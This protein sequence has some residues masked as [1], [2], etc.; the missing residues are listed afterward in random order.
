MAK[1]QILTDGFPRA[2]IDI[3]SIR[4]IRKSLI[5]KQN[6]LTALMKEVEASLI[7]LHQ[8]AGSSGPESPPPQARKRAF[9]RVNSV[10]P[11]SPASLA[12]LA[13]GDKI[14][15]YGSVDVSNH[16]NLQR[17]A[18]ETATNE[19]KQIDVQVERVV[20]GQPRV[21]SISLVPKQGWGGRGLLGCHILPL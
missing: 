5:Y 20:D 16:D 3:V 8:A 12:G 14:L 10:A 13:A 7:N 1:T 6:D 11:S 17:L 19:N 2:D 9:A 18:S 4:Q 15:C 21:V